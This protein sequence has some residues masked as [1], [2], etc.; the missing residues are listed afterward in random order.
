[1]KLLILG[2]GSATPRLDRLP[3]SQLIEQGNNLYLIDC[4]EGTQFQFLKY[5]VKPSRLKA[6][7]ISH[8]HGDHYL[9]LPGLLSTFHLQGRKEPIHLFGPLEI[10]NLLEHHFLIGATWLGYE[11]RYHVLTENEKTAIYSD[12]EIEVSAFPLNHRIACYGYQ[13]AEKQKQRKINKGLIDEFKLTHEEIRILKTGKDV[14]RQ[15]GKKLQFEKLTF[16]SHTPVIYSFCSDTA[17]FDELNDFIINSDWLYH[18]ATF[19]ESLKQKAIDTFHS[20]AA[21]AAKA[22]QKANVSNLILGH[23][24]A[25]YDDLEQFKSEAQSYFEKV[26]LAFDGALFELDKN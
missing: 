22:A 15:D 18:E 7:F 25:R 19:V 2:S 20:T 12:D 3:T 8:L 17:P 6:I 16:V 14:K 4:C 5:K 13:F 11:I 24:S 10:K 1:M 21:D 23:F 9:G 26:Y